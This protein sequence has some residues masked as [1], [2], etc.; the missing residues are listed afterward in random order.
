MSSRFSAIIAL[1]RA[2]F[3][4]KVAECKRFEG[5]FCLRWEDLCV[6]IELN[7]NAWAKIPAKL[8]GGAN[9]ATA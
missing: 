7:H 5:N 2:I 6:V 1:F 8:Y 9:A 4:R 3:D